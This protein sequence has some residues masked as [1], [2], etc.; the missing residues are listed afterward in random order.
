MIAIEVE[1][2][3][4]H[5]AH[6]ASATQQARLSFTVQ[7]DG[8]PRSAIAA[9]V[10][11]QI[12]PPEEI[13][14]PERLRRRRGAGPSGSPRGE[15]GERPCAPVG[16]RLRDRG[17]GLLAGH[18]PE[19]TAGGQPRRAKG[20]D[21]RNG[22]RRAES[23]GGAPGHRAS[24]RRLGCR[25]LRPRPFTLA[26]RNRRSPA[27]RL[28]GESMITQPWTP[29]EG[30]T[31]MSSS[32]TCRSYTSS[33]ATGVP[34]PVLRAHSFSTESGKAGLASSGTDQEPARSPRQPASA[35][36]AGRA[37]AGSVRSRPCTAWQDP[38]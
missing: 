21:L 3:L 27:S 14:R 15:G 33:R 24:C 26:A 8:V 25:V 34:G 9:G 31:G 36:L 10:A 35:Q 18:S 29:D 4:F 38:S 23:P 5:T 37:G 12:L 28:P 32:G 16:R 30:R 1:M 2:G 19:R 6:P 17:G 13:S 7:L 11:D 22:S 20:A